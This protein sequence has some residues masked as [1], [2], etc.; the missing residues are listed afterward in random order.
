MS[1][2]EW[3]PEQAARAHSLVFLCL[4]HGE[5]QGVVASM[6]DHCRIIDLAAD[7]RLRQPAA[8]EAVYGSP[9]Q[10]PA[11][12]G[13]AVYGL[14]EWSRKDLAGAALVAGPGCFAT[15]ALLGLLPL[16]ASGLLGEWVC[17]DGKTGSCGS[18][19][20]PRW[21]THHPERAADF[22]AYS[23]LRHRHAAEMRQ[24]LARHSGRSLSLLFAP[25]S[26]PMVRGLFTTLFVDLHR[27]ARLQE[28]REIYDRCYAREPFLRICEQ[29]R[30]AAVA[31]SNFC[32]IGLAS[33]GGRQAVICTA[34]DNLLKGAAAQAVQNMNVMFGWEE[35]AGLLQP[36]AYPS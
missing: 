31:G 33:E 30:V 26:A 36:A 20:R 7:F 23:L 29:P 35:T 9:H 5:S 8:Y 25:H 24:E 4:E 6:K 28:L 13:T 17:V 11:L 15:G 21:E 14:T 18:G 1:F 19:N 16:A 10:A 32:E 34:I 2:S 27:P 12:L 22:R 3:D